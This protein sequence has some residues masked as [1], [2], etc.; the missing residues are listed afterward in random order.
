MVYF[1][2]AYHYF[3]TKAEGCDESLVDSK[4]RWILRV[5]CHHKILLTDFDKNPFAGLPELTNAD[6]AFCAGSCPTQSWSTAIMIELLHDM[7]E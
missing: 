6:G 5:L 1:L 4:R 2:R 7:S 3:F